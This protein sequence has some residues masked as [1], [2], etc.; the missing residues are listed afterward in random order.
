MATHISLEPVELPADAIEMGRI[1]DAW[2]IKGWFKVL[3]FSSTP[4]ALYSAKRW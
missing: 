2:G 1:T 3:P 4:E